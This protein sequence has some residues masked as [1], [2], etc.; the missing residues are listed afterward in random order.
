[1]Q[2]PNELKYEQLRQIRLD[3]EQKAYLSQM[4]STNLF[5]SLLVSISPL[6]RSSIHLTGVAYQEAD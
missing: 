5:T 4:F 2:Q 3:T 6:Q 1:M